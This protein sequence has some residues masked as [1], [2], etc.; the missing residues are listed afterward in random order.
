M[1][2]PKVSYP[3]TY[4]IPKSAIY[5][6]TPTDTVEIYVTYDRQYYGYDMETIVLTFI[7]RFTTVDSTY[8]FEMIDTQYTFVLHGKEVPNNSNIE[9][10]GTV[11]FF[12]FLV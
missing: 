7:D 12:L 4:S 1:F 5:A 11:T 8:G 2:G 6:V 3:F 9:M 10:M